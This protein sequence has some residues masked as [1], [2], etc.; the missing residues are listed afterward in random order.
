LL[1]DFLK[2]DGKSADLAAKRLF[3]Q[4]RMF[5]GITPYNLPVALMFLGDEK[6]TR[7]ISSFS[8]SVKRDLDLPMVDGGVYM[9]KW[10]EGDFNMIPKINKNCF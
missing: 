9:T 10:V 8:V 4:Y 6:A 5:A 2:V 1:F 3:A 7:T